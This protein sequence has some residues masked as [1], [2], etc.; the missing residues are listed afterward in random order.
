MDYAFGVE[1]KM[2]VPFL[3]EGQEEEYERKYIVY[4][5]FVHV[6]SE[7]HSQDGEVKMEDLSPPD[8]NGP[9]IDGRAPRQ[10]R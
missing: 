4:N 3:T 9:S 7:S 8:H 10:S 6:S 5:K 1:K 2:V